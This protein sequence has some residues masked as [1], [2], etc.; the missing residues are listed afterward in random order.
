MRNGHSSFRKK[1]E[2]IMN[3]YPYTQSELYSKK[4]N[5]YRGTG[6]CGVAIPVLGNKHTASRTCAHTVRVNY[7]Q[8]NV[9]Q[10]ENGTYKR[11]GHSGV[12]IPV[13]GNK[14]LAV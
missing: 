4:C 11:T 6:H 7:N 12:D 8:K 13:L 14:W 3:L 2:C 1:A 10:E 9:A 5:L